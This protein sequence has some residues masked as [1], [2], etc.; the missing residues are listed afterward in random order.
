MFALNPQFQQN[1]YIFRSAYI[2]NGAHR[3]QWYEYNYIVLVC[4]PQ[5]RVVYHGDIRPTNILVTRIMTAKLGDLG[6][7]RFSDVSLTVGLVSPPYAAPERMDGRSGKKSKETDIYSMGVSICELFTGLQPIRKD[8]RD[9]V[10]EISDKEVR[11]LC[12]RM[13]SDD[14][15]ERPSAAEALTVV[16]HLREC[17]DYKACPPRRMVKGKLDGAKEVTF[18]DRMW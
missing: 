8:R 15:R 9:Q 7:A 1:K 13:V 5:P 17:K 18:A 10:D 16:G 2:T 11:D 6:A 4:A 3:L 14:S 12:M